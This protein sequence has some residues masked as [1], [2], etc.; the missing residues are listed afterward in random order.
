ME[1]PKTSSKILAVLKKIL[2]VVGFVVAAAFFAAV[3]AVL[4]S[5][6]LEQELNLLALNGVE[7]TLA[8]IETGTF[9]FL[10]GLL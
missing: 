6:Y 2:I 9:S 3:L 5:G 7:Y 4:N 10:D 1:T 8:E